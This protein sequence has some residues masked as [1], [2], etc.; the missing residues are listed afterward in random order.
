MTVSGG[1]P[2]S[3]ASGAVAQAASNSA[4]LIEV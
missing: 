1:G 4:A 3:A 2:E